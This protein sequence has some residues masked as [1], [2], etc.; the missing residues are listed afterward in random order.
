MYAPGAR[1]AADDAETSK[2]GIVALS[3][4]LFCE[5][6]AFGAGV[7]VLCPSF[8][9]SATMERSRFTGGDPAITAAAKTM[10]LDPR[11][12]PRSSQ[13]AHSL[14]ANAASSTADAH[15][16]PP[17]RTPRRRWHN[18]ARGPVARIT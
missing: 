3:E 2:A 8:F 6:S 15:R 18:L 12:K 16:S 11:Y 17:S 5:L 1:M 13:S 10:M 4:T 9:A 14:A 7:K